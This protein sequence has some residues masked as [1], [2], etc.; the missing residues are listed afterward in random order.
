[1]RKNNKWFAQKRQKVIFCDI[2]VHLPISRE[3][4]IY[5]SVSHQ[6]H[7]QPHFQTAGFFHESLT[8][9]TYLRILCCNQGIQRQ[10]IFFRM[11][12]KKA[13]KAHLQYYASKSQNNNVQLL[14]SL[15]QIPKGSIHDF[16]L[17]LHINDSQW[18]WDQTSARKKMFIGSDIHS[19]LAFS[20]SVC[21]Q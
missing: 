8:S 9:V 10:Q 1:M 15:A 3:T 18:N 20:L 14:L 16:S 6:C 12:Q 19:F 17:L 13:R 11:Y 21:I 2:F 4:R 7:L 5:V